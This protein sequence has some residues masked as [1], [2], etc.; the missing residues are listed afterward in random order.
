[1]SATETNES[2]TDDGI[3]EP[4]RG[5]LA[6]RIVKIGFG[7]AVLV[8]GAVYIGARWNGVRDAIANARPAWIVVAIVCAAAGQWAA[9]FSFGAVLRMIAP[10]L[11][12]LEV[13][14]VQF[15]SQLGKYI[16]GSIWP[17]VVITEM[18]RRYGIARRSAATAGV[19]ALLYSLIVATI[20]GLVL[21]LAA[22]A[23]SAAGWWWLVAIIPIGIALVHPRV[24]GAAV[25]AVLRLLRRPPIELDLRWQTLRA[26]LGWSALSWVLLGLQCWALVVALG[27][28]LGKSLAPAIGGFA[29]AYAAG[30]IFIPAPAGAGVREAA[31][32]LALSGFGATAATLTHDEIVVV[33]LLS[34][35][36]LAILDFAQA[37]VVLLL[38]RHS[39][40]RAT[41]EA[42]P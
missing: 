4:R 28:D 39:S 15:V 41:P 9:A 18:G 40:Q 21:V 35:V 13:A 14:R 10:P 37:G 22:S 19:L 20:L 32:G 29:L 16:P 3:A 11:P 42:H 1:V 8:F 27:G 2:A 33:V 5:S 30:T 25:D 34:R 26:C 6:G 38:A 12:I 36:I 7:L 24:V 17:I 31:L 23:G